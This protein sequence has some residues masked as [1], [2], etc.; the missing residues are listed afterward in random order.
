MDC[1]EAMAKM[2]DKAFDLAIVDPPYGLDFASERRRKPTA[3]RSAQFQWECKAWDV[4]TPDA[5]YFSELLRVSTNQII[6]GGNYFWEYLSRT[7]CVI[8]WNKENPEGMRFADGEMAWA[9]FRTAL[10]IFSSERTY[11]LEKQY[12]PTQKP[13]ALYKW[14]LQNYAKEGQ[15]ILDTHLGSGSS[16]IAAHKAVIDYIYQHVRASPTGRGHKVWRKMFDYQNDEKVDE[17]EKQPT[18][19]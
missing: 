13:V 11:K 18:L 2:P 9:S 7:N 3:T 5:E 14:L 12:H 10:R 6:W 8:V 1:M 17:P 19:F 15:T 4:A 16:R